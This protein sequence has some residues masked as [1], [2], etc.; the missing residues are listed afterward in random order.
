MTS[1]GVVLGD[2]LVSIITSSYER[3]RR[4]WDG[5]ILALCSK[6]VHTIIFDRSMVF[7][8]SN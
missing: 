4:I 6:L 1:R 3:L 7:K 5:N 8:A 2:L